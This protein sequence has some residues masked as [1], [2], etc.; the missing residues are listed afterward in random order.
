MLA[1]EVTSI[2]AQLTIPAFV[3]NTV[4]PISRFGIDVTPEFQSYTIAPS[5]TFNPPYMVEVAVVDVALNEGIVRVEYR[6][7]P[8][9]AKFATPAID[10]SEPGVV[11]PIPI[12]SI[13]VITNGVLPVVSFFIPKLRFVLSKPVSIEYAD[14]PVLCL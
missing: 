13:F 3:S 11:V 12:L 5:P 1:D 7:E 2:S 6:V 14:I 10:R 9:P 4:E 8:V